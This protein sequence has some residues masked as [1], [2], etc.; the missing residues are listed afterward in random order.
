MLDGHN[1]KRAKLVPRK[2]HQI[3]FIANNAAQRRSWY[4]AMQKT[5]NQ[6]IDS[7]KMQVKQKYNG[8]VLVYF[9]TYVKVR[10]ESQPSLFFKGKSWSN[11]CRKIQ[12]LFLPKNCIWFLSKRRTMNLLHT[13][14]IQIISICYNITIGESALCIVWPVL[15]I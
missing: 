4:P 11:L 12:I 3:C 13:E 7:R 9:G 1:P 8:Q 15:P 6:C 2:R 10:N 5:R 14:T